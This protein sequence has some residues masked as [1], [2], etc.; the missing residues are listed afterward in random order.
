MWYRNKQGHSNGFTVFFDLRDDS[1]EES[2]SIRV[3]MEQN[4]AKKEVDF[5][6]MD[7]ELSLIHI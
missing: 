7:V 3:L 4:D 5:F 6:H 2:G 1:D